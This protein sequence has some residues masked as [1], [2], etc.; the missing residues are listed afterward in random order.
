MHVPRRPA[1]FRY[2]LAILV[3]SIVGTAAELVLARHYDTPW[4]IAPLALFGVALFAIV[5]ALLR[6]GNGTIGAFRGIMLLFVISGAIGVVLHYQGKAEFALE[7]NKSLGG[8][9]LLRET[10]LKGTSPPLLAPGTMIALGLLGLV[11]AHGA[12]ERH[13]PHTFGEST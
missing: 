9:A 2:V 11:W 8:W 7:R 10:V 5:M 6:P 1:V 12:A 13:T 4:K 3:F